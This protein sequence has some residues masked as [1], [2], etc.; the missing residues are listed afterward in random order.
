MNYPVLCLRNHS[1]LKSLTENIAKFICFSNK[2]C[3]QSCLEYT[4]NPSVSGRKNSSEDYAANSWER[5][6]SIDW[7]MSSIIF[8]S[9][10]SWFSFLKLL[11]PLQNIPSNERRNHC[12]LCMRFASIE[13]CVDR[14]VIW[15]KRRSDT[16]TLNLYFLKYQFSY[17]KKDLFCLYNCS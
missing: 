1:F 15:S 14:A 13:N 17:L 4:C 6:W 8:Q 7:K 12:A 2:I 16:G 5:G 3:I 9:L 10:G 11:F